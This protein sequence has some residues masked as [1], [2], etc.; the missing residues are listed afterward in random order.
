MGTNRGN[1]TT[2][3]QIPQ[4]AKAI[5]TGADQTD[6]AKNT[7]PDTTYVLNVWNGAEPVPGLS[8]LYADKPTS[9]NS[10]LLN[11]P[12]FMAG[13][14]YFD[15]AAKWYV[16][17]LPKDA[18]GKSTGGIAPA[19]YTGTGK[20]F[21][22]NYFRTGIQATP[23][24]TAL[25]GSADGEA[26][27]QILMKT[28]AYWVAVTHVMYNLDMA[29]KNLAANNTAAAASN[30]DSA[31][32]A[33]YGCGDT[34]PVPLPFYKGSVIKYSATAATLDTD[35]NA[36]TMSIYGVANKRADNYG[37]QGFVS[38]TGGTCTVASTTC[39][40]V[41]ALNTV[42]AAALSGGPSTAN[43]QTI[44]D[45]VLTIFT[46]AAQRYAAKL[47]LSANLPGNGMGGSTNPDTV[48]GS[49]NPTAGSYIP[50]TIGGDNNLKK[51]PTA[52][53]GKTSIVFTAKAASTTTIE[54]AAGALGMMACGPV[55]VLAA[56]GAGCAANG[57]ANAACPAVGDGCRTVT[58]VNAC[59]VNGNV[60]AAGSPE[61]NT[62][63]F[64][65]VQQT[66]SSVGSN[67]V[68]PFKLLAAAPVTNG[69]AGDVGKGGGNTNAE[70]EAASRGR[71]TVGTAT[72]APIGCIGPDVQFAEITTCG[73][74]DGLTCAA[75]DATSNRAG[76]GLKLCVPNGKIPPPGVLA[77]TTGSTRIAAYRG[78][79]GAPGT[80]AN[81]GSSLTGFWDPV[82]VALAT[83]GAF[84][85]N[86]MVYSS[87]GLGRPDMT[88][89]AKPSAF[90]PPMV[91]GNMVAEPSPGGM[92][93][94]ASTTAGLSAYKNPTQ[95]NQLEGQAF[96]ACMAPMQYTL[97]TTSANAA[98]QKIRA[99]KQ[100]ICAETITKMLKI[101][102]AASAS[103]PT[104]T[105]GCVNRN[106]A[107]A[108]LVAVA[109]F[110][111]AVGTLTNAPTA[112]MVANAATTC[113]GSL[114]G[115]VQFPLWK[116]GIGGTTTYGS[117]TDYFV[118]SGY[119]YA[120]AC[121]QDFAEVGTQS[122]FLGTA[123]LGSLVKSPDM[124]SAPVSASPTTGA[125]RA[126]KACAAAPTGWTG[127]AAEFKLCPLTQVN[128]AGES[129]CTTAQ[130]QAQTGRIPVA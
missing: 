128:T 63:T 120:N 29:E 74:A 109:P 34:N 119:C 49:T 2:L 14:Q 58:G 85:C 97:Q 77:A 18:A 44:K 79:A 21:L 126:N 52:C 89:I 56:D 66:V 113:R 93:N 45:S 98:T 68:A 103:T 28:S 70:I 57:A 36:T 127:A 22:D 115:A 41:A 124:A 82:T 20:D 1:W 102:S 116:V 16:E 73:I 5:A 81:P 4:Q 26:N 107:P 87:E 46:Q 80:A 24:A 122:T 86:S 125:G 88:G 51:Q 42:V 90:V 38:T 106:Q 50:S 75:A 112:A 71:T 25:S 61:S 78:T 100:K 27:S 39:K 6:L 83:N 117:Q 65:A 9:Y 37:T 31:A 111:P 94:G 7:V 91:G 110:T 13:T 101:D 129:T 32:A 96:Y 3:C 67:P 62:V 48:T 118:P 95:V 76:V 43:I 114:A 33:Y 55:N 99:D 69:D 11:T 130:I 108:N 35:F 53:G 92:Y 47:S 121:F 30:F 23:S 54:A 104:A 40:K 17:G 12:Y 10:A 64:G 59:S 15:N 105:T 84:C 123:K 72:S 8:A 60:P 19:T